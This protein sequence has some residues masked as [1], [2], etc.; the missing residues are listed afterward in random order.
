VPFVLTTVVAIRHGY[1]KGFCFRLTDKGFLWPRAQAAKPPR[2][3]GG[4]RSEKAVIPIR[5]LVQ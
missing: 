4:C 1:S 3:V 2:I 5:T